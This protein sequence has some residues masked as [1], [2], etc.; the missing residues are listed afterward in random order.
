MQM[1]YP[2]LEKADLRRANLEEVFLKLT[3]EKLVDGEKK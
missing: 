1:L 2:R 3:G